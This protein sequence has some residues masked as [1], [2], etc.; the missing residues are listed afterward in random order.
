MHDLTTIIAIN[1]KRPAPTMKNR[2]GAFTERER[3]ILIRS[4]LDSLLNQT[5]AYRT[6]NDATI[7]ALGEEGR[8]PTTYFGLE[9]L[10]R[11]IDEISGLDPRPEAA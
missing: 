5:T 7:R 10:G 6:A 1:E 3:T 11:L 2:F 8:L 9:T 4:L